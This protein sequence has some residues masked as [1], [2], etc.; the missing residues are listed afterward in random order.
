MANNIINHNPQILAYYWYLWGLRHYVDKDQM[1]TEEITRQVIKN[2]PIPTSE[3][4]ALLEQ[5]LQQFKVVL[6]NQKSMVNNEVHYA[7]TSPFMV[8]ISLHRFQIN[9][10]LQFFC[11]HC[12]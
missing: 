2:M 4:L 3:E 1:P 10:V 9:N 6:N 11:M 5:H 7:F 8:E 12:K